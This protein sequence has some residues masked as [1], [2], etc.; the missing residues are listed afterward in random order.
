MVSSQEFA[1]VIFRGNRPQE[2][3]PHNADPQVLLKVLI[4]RLLPRYNDVA[5]RYPVDDLL[6]DSNQVAD[7][8]FVRAVFAY[9][10]TL[11]LDHFPCGLHTWPPTSIPLNRMPPVANSGTSVFSSSAGSSTATSAPSSSTGTSASSSSVRVPSKAL[12]PAQKQ[13]RIRRIWQA[14][15]S[16]AMALAASKAPAVAAH[17]APPSVSASKAPAVSKAPSVFQKWADDSLSGGRL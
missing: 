3:T 17:K 5:G 16:S 6:R 10:A 2:M 4:N 12:R 13:D 9:S 8:A 11:G 1:E 15:P 14:L 7:G